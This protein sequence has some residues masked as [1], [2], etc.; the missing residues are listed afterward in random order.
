M[1]VYLPIAAVSL[2]GF[3]LLALGTAV[4]FLS[5]VFGVGGG[6]L[7]T[8]L[9]IV[10]GVPHAV[11]VAT[12]ANQIV[13]ASLSG[14]LG[15]WR[16][17]NIDLAMG[18][19][20]L[21]GGVAGSVVGVS[22]FALLLRFGQV[23]TVIDLSYTVLLG[24]LGVLMLTEATRA[25]RRS[26]RPSAPPRRLHVHTWMHGLPLKMRFRRSRLYISM[27]LPLGLGF[28]VG[29]LS[30]AMGVGGGFLMVPAMI[31]LLGMPTSM[32]AGTSLFQIIF[33]SAAITVLQAVENGTVDIVLAFI[34]LVGGVIGARLGSRFA[35]QLRGEFLRAALA[36][37][38]LAV[39]VKLGADLVATPAQ[40]FTLKT[41]P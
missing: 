41:L 30:A 6:F 37:L 14:A 12:S 39:A 8:P 18:L 10:V 26:R 7:L 13:G 38:V 25:W 28:G 31:Y 16:R 20:M 17:D 36:V 2:D 23:V 22:F 32:V 29:A 5:G 11:A 24:I 19:V 40:I 1:D 21:V 9:L 4:G 35:T 27:L 15:H 34:L 3:V 33:V